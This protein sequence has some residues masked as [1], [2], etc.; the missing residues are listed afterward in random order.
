M[1]IEI[2]EEKSNNIGYYGIEEHVE[3]MKSSKSYIKHGSLYIR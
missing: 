1:Q 2:T 3:L